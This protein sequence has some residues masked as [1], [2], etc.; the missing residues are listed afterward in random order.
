MPL[1]ILW[2]VNELSEKDFKMKLQQYDKDLNK[3]LE[4]GQVMATFI[5]ILADTLNSMIDD[6][7]STIETKCRTFD[8]TYA[9]MREYFND[10]LT[11]ISN[12]Y[13]CSVPW[14]GVDGI[15]AKST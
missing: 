11:G 3:R 4:I 10:V 8:E 5:Q 1:R 14:I 12:A 13:G 6:N 7:V 2:M 9:N 15:H